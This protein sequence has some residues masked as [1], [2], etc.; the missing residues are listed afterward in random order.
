MNKVIRAYTQN[1]LL[2]LPAIFSTIRGFYYFIAKDSN[3]WQ[4]TD[5]LIN[6]DQGLIRRGLSGT[7]LLK[8]SNIFGVIDINIFSL[9]LTLLCIWIINLLNITLSKGYSFI[10]RLKLCVST[11]A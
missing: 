7:L 4:A 10:N 6:N 9:F 8:Y 2:F 1:T 3:S 11:F 5:W